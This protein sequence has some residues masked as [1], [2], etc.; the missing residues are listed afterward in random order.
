MKFSIVMPWYKQKTELVKRAILSILNQ[1]YHDVELIICDNGNI[2]DED[3]K[4]AKEYIQELMKKDNRIIFFRSDVNVGW[5]KCIALCLEKAT[6]DYM[7]FIADDDYLE[8]T[9]LD[10]VN[11]EIQMYNPDI[12][13][14]GVTFDSFDGKNFNVAG[15]SIPTYKVLNNEQEIREYSIK[16]FSEVYYNAMHHYIRMDLLVT[17][18]INFYDKFYSDCGAM[19]E[20]FAKADKMVIL[21]RAPYHLTQETSKT[22]GVYQKGYYRMFATQWES[23]VKFLSKTNYFDREVLTYF[24]ARIERNHLSLIQA[25]CSQSKCRNDLFESVEMDNQDRLIEI[26]ETLNYS[27]MDQ[28]MYFYGRKEYMYVIV[29]CLI[30][31]LQDEYDKKGSIEDIVRKTKFLGGFISAIIEIHNGK[32][33]ICE[34]MDTT[35][36]QQ[37]IRAIDDE[38]NKTMFGYELIEGMIRNVTETIDNIFKMLNLKN[39][40]MQL[41]RRINNQFNLTC[42]THNSEG[43]KILSIIKVYEG[44]NQEV[45][46]FINAILSQAIS[47]Y[48]MEILFINNTGS[49][50]VSKEIVQLEMSYGDSVGIINL[51]EKVDRNTAEEI[52]MQYTSGRYIGKS[53]LVNQDKMYI[54]LI[55]NDKV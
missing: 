7:G 24:S 1:T 20:V 31:L 35:R 21:D 17:N 48:E 55:K 44:N 5:P 15:V 54:K 39:K 26:E 27:F 10:E 43:E 50:M 4:R 38:N 11:K 16:F 37:L 6:G 52:G 49:E 30:E 12:V 33:M 18:H 36:C 3:V 14:M 8:P 23:L 53:V 34:R 42:K 9:A 46:E 25:L 13:W 51:E 22:S 47:I 28:L 2:E 19:T 41:E 40:Y 29:Q 32:V 45:S